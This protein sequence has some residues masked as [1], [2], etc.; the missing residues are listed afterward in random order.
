MQRSF[1]SAVLALFIAPHSLVPGELLSAPKDYHASYELSVGSSTN[2]FD[3]DILIDSRDGSI[4]REIDLEDDLGFDNEVNLTWINA[5]WRIADRHALELIYTP[6]RRATYFENRKDIDLG[7]KVIKAGASI[8]SDVKTHLFDIEYTYSLYKDQQTE[9]G[10][11]GGIYWMNSLTSVNA[12]GALQEEGSED[13]QF[14]ESFEKSQRLVVPLPLFGLSA[15]HWLSDAWK[16]SANARIL[17]V[18]IN[19]IDGYLLN[20][21][22]DTSY[23]FTDH[24]GIGLS[25]SSF[26]LRVSQQRVIFTNSI[27]Y[28]YT[29]LLGYVTLRY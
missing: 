3:T 28:G 20:L 13:V 19:D 9:V 17:D 26:D 23:Y 4:S 22:M 6:I 7:D 5:H 2:V 12:K 27:K 25:L 15:S 21:N 14:V 11:S 8:S 1:K 24:V 29:G 18:T 10:I 16:V